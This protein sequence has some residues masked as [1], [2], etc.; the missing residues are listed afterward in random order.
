MS[1]HDAFRLMSRED[2]AKAFFFIAV[3]VWAMA[4]VL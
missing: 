2:A 4:P 3:A 1:E